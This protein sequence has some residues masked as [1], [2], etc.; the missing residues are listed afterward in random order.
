MNIPGG[1][2]A[3]RFGAK[4][5]LLTALITASIATLLTPMVVHLG[6]A[7]AL[8]VLRF[9]IGLSQGGLF[10]AINVLLTVWVPLSERSRMASLIYCGVPVRSISSTRQIELIAIYLELD[11]CFLF[12]FGFAL[13][14]S[15]RSA[16]WWATRCAAFYWNDMHGQLH[17]MCSDRPDVDFPFCMCVCNLASF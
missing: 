3:Q 9:M 1:Q 13:F 5:V 2:L 10:P 6:G 4:P 8:I 16:C 17:F 14:C 12:L 7:H 11:F 15:C